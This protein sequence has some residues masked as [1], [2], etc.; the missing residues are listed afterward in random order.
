VPE[1]LLSDRGTNL[2]SHLMTDLCK[3]LGIK[4]LNMTAYHPE[5][6]GMVERFNRI[7]KTCLRKHAAT[8]GNQWDKYLYGVLYAYR[9]ISHESIG[10]KPSY[11]LY[12]TDCQTP[13]E[14]AI[15]PPSPMSWSNVAD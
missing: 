6:D 12:G 1:C 10:E 4:K 14:A 13:S 3:M 9:N 11:L 5:C 15:L 2:L 8:H 7:L